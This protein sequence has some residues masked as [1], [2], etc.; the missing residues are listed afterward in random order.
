LNFCD[1]GFE[2]KYLG[3]KF[4]LAVILELALHSS[5]P[6]K[7]LEHTTVI[8]YTAAMLSGGTESPLP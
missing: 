2:S 1:F 5:P 4:S 3:A 8:F 7:E 6:T